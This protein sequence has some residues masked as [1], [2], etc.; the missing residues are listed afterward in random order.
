MKTIE[1]APSAK[2]TRIYGDAKIVGH[3]SDGT[4]T[5]TY[6]LPGG[7]TFSQL[8]IIR[9]IK[10][11]QRRLA[12]KYAFSAAIAMASKDWQA[13]EMLNRHFG[14]EFGKFTIKEGR[15]GV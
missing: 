5:Y 2:N 10:A 4:R 6:E 3:L 11:S 1:I 15:T 9:K 13:E 8:D 7:H 14:V 12:V